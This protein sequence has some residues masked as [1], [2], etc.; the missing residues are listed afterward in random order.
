MEPTPNSL[1]KTVQNLEKYFRLTFNRRTNRLETGL[2]YRPSYKIQ[3]KMCTVKYA[4][5]IVKFVGSISR[6]LYNV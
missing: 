5:K 4:F 1:V 3:C 6:V 2:I